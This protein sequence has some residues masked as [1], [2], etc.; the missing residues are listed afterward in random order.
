MILSQ[1]VLQDRTAPAPFPPPGPGT[2]SSDGLDTSL[3][4]VAAAQE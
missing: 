4:A 3:Q 1:V 2:P